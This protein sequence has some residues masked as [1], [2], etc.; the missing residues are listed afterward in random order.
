MLLGGGIS[1][2]KLKVEGTAFKIDNSG[3]LNQKYLLIQKGKKNYW[4]VEAV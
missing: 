1:I 4:L 3:L 2:N